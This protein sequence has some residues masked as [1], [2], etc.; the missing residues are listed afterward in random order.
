[1]SN[2]SGKGLVYADF[3]EQAG[4]DS[5]EVQAFIDDCLANGI[6]LH[7]AIAIRHGKVACEAYSAPFTKDSPH[8]M[9]SVSKSFTGTAIG[10]AIDE[11]LISLDTKVIDIFPEYKQEKHDKRLDDMTIFHL[12][13]MTAGKDVSV[14]S[15]KS[16]NK[17]VRDFFR[18]KWYAEPGKEWKYISEATYMCSVIIR[19][20][21]GMTM[22][23]YLTP[24]LFKPL[25]IERRP[26][27]E[28]DGYGI[29]AGG[30]GLFVTP[31]ELAKFTLCYQQKG[32][33]AS[34]QVIPEWWAVQATRGLVKNN[35]FVDSDIPDNNNSGYGFYFWR[36]EL[37]DSFRCDGMFSQFGFV[38]ENY[39]ACFVMNASEVDETK[40]MNVF[41]KHIP[42]MFIDD[43][44]EKP[45]G[46]KVPQIPAQ[47]VPVNFRRSST[48]RKISGKTIRFIKNPLLN[49]I[50]FPLSVLPL[51]AVYMSAD[52]AGNIDNLSLTFFDDYCIFTWDEG[53]EHN[54]ICCGMNGQP[55]KGRMRLGGINY[56][57]LSYA[58]WKDDSTLEVWIRPMES[59]AERRFEI[60]FGEKKVV[61]KPM[62]SPPLSSIADNLAQ[63]AGT[64]VPFKPLA[65]LAAEA[66]RKIDLVVEAPLVGFFE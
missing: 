34:K 38:F 31:E 27:W 65:D 55:G 63:G 64:V 13:T 2:S 24:R 43:C 29:E 30:W 66:L 10:F 18:A 4:I 44:A 9:Y 15:D 49:A 62:S 35:G 39:D 33:Y 28:C 11:G 19:R 61:M 60:T 42:K 12:L 36:N 45:E 32:V 46:A 52:R 48:E 58:S 6:E 51:A 56:S 8:A 1:M 23:D 21:T 3:A 47:P 59:V 53:K 37:E 57:T 50:G 20:V 17:W 5:K 40:S 22:V 25:G 54:S 41:F 26:Q 16:K 7:S 14:L